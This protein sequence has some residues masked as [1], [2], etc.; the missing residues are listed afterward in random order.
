VALLQKLRFLETGQ[1]V[2][3]NGGS[4]NWTANCPRHPDHDPG[5]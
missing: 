1:I 2:D 3:V 4:P 5:C